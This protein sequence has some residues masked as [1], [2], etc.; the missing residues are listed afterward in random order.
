[1]HVVDLERRLAADDTGAARDELVDALTAETVDVNRRLAV[2][3]EPDDF[4]AAQ[5]WLAGCA[6]ATRVVRGFWQGAHSA[7]PRF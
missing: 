1:M 4:R 3:M 7:R 2:G 6:A 5:A